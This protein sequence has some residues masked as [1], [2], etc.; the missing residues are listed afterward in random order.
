[1]SVINSVSHNEEGKITLQQI[2]FFCSLQ[3]RKKSFFRVEVNLNLFERTRSG[4]GALATPDD[5]YITP[6]L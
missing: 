1:M 2:L 4:F 6:I 3:F 5:A